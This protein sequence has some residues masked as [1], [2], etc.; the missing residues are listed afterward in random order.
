MTDEKEPGVRVE[1]VDGHWAVQVAENGE[2]IQR[3]FEIEEYARNFAEG[4][5]LRLGL[6]ASSALTL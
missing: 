4:Q 5:R 1:H 3:L 2:V 6:P